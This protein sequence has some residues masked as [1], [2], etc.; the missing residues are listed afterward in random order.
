VFLAP[1]APFLP[2]DFVLWLFGETGTLKS[3]LLALLLS[4]FGKFTRTSLPANWEST[5]NALE[6][7]TF[8]AKDVPLVLD[9]Y[10]PQSS[11]L[12][13]S[14]LERKV[15]RIIRAAGNRSGRGR[16]RSDTSLRASYP[17]RGMVLSSG[18]QLPSGQ[19]I[20]ARTLAV[21]VKHGDVDLAKLSASQDSAHLLPHGMA[22]YLLWI[23]NHWDHLAE[24]L[25]RRWRTIRDE[26]VKENHLRLPEIFASLCLAVD[27]ALTYAVELDALSRPDA[28]EIRQKG[29]LVLLDLVKKQGERIEG[30]K[31]TL[32]FL[33]VLNELLTQG[34]VYV[35][36]ADGTTSAYPANAEHIGWQ[37]DDY[38]YLLPKAVFHRVAAF[39]RSEGGYFP[40]KRNTLYRQL[41][42]EGFSERDKKGGRYTVV[43]RVG[44][45][46]SERVLKLRRA[47]MEKALGLGDTAENR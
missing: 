9:D 5:A 38:L 27:T 41:Y 28:D 30:E 25:P 24:T 6:K 32:Q 15:T 4:H 14:E 21:E 37:D 39:C 16:M 7:L 26:T 18:E 19:S 10:A 17:P 47:T 45:D 42:E 46:K 44:T 20:M 31:A 1:L 43:Q 34:A 11:G 35:A 3:T 22:G 33:E 13:A 23:A 40:V 8:L 36:P 12:D 2:I 29:K